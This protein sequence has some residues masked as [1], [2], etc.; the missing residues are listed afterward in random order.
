VLHTSRD[1][2]PHEGR[3]LALIVT[4]A[5][6]GLELDNVTI[7]DQHA[8]TVFS[9]EQNAQSDPVGTV[10]AL[11]NQHI[12]R[13][14]SDIMRL[15]SL[16]FHEV[17]PMVQL[18]FGEN[19][20]EERIQE[21]FTA[22][23][24]FDGGIAFEEER[25]QAQMEGLQGGFEPGGAWNQ[26]AI[27]GYAMGGPGNISASQRDSFTQYHVNRQEIISQTGP[28]WIDVN[29]S[30][31][32]VT[33][34]NW[35]YVYQ[36]WWMEQEEGRTAADW[37]QFVRENNTPTVVNGN[38]PDF[39]EAHALLVI[40]TGLPAE[41][42][43]LTI[44]EQVVPMPTMTTPWNIPLFV[45]LAVLVLL[46]LMLA[47]GLLQR[48]KSGDEDEEAEPELSVEDLL[49]STQLE[50]AKEE[51]K[52]ELDAIEYFKDNEVKKHIEKFVNEKP[53][54]VASLLRNWI[55]AEEW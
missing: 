22:P 41:N 11:R 52:E 54:A 24:G 55:N 8:R 29:R 30:T 7:I 2:P 25:R 4:R 5:V 17:Q 37:D 39:E 40:A 23:D 48:Q 45:M 53:E 47:Y 13:V 51:A 44:M 31:V 6:I 28:D 1:I 34:T 3:N 18:T 20:F 46:L 26:A 19:I 33:A 35:L 36:G 49:V 14:N 9:Y 12:N 10:Q 38:F 16:M 27:P 32:A 42:V 15:F 21:I 43:H 50:E